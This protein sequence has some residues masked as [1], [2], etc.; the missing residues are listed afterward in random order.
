MKTMGLPRREIRWGPR[1][2]RISTRDTAFR[3]EHPGVAN[4]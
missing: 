3:I 4:N 1:A 2:V